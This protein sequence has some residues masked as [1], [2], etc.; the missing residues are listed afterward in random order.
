MTEIASE[1]SPYDRVGGEVKVR[2]AAV[3]FHE[4]VL[5]DLDEPALKTAFHFYP[6]RSSPSKGKEFSSHG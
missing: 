5:S 2:V 1:V 3:L 4:R 6:V